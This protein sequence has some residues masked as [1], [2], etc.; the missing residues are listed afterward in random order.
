MSKLSQRPISLSR[1]KIRMTSWLYTNEKLRLWHGMYVLLLM[2]LALGRLVQKITTDSGGFVSRYIP[3]LVIALLITG[4]IGCISKIPIF[5]RLFW[6][7]IFW[8]MVI[9]DIAL[10]SYALYLLLGQMSY[11]TVSIFITLLLVT[12]PAQIA[13][14]RYSKR[15]C[16]VWA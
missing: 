6:L 14:Y 13:L 7:C 10:L 9:A 3:I 16:V 5:N 1:M 4:F 8:C 2:A 12:L 15:Q 11:L